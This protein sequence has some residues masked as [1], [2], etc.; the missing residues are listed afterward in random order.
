MNDST[1]NTSRQKISSTMSNCPSPP[2]PFILKNLKK[3]DRPTY[4]PPD[5]LT[6]AG[7]RHAYASKKVPSDDVM[8]KHIN[9]EEANTCSQFYSHKK[10]ITTKQTSF[11]PP[12]LTLKSTALLRAASLA[13]LFQ[14]QNGLQTIIP[15][16]TSF[17]IWK[18]ISLMSNS[19]DFTHTH[20]SFISEE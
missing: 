11:L 12:P 10:I 13:P 6:G 16:S 8:M 19:H 7:A 2:R 14:P 17:T 9:H 1:I 3:R 15:L 20:L 18:E 4:L 5:L